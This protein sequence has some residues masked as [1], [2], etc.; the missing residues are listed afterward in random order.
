[1]S[2]GK[3]QIRSDNGKIL[4]HPSGKIMTEC[5]C[6]KDPEIELTGT[7]DFYG[8]ECD[9]D[10]DVLN[11]T[12]KN[13]GAVGSELTWARTLDMDAGLVGQLTALPASGSLAKDASEVIA[14][15]LDKN[16]LGAGSY[17]G[18]LTAD[19]QLVS[20]VTPGT[21]PITVEIVT[22][23]SFPATMYSHSV[24]GAPVYALGG[25][26]AQRKSHSFGY[27]VLWSQVCGRKPDGVW[28]ELRSPTA[29][30]GPLEMWYNPAYAFE[31]KYIYSVGNT[32][33]FF[34]E[35]ATAPWIGTTPGT[36]PRWPYVWNRGTEPATVA[37]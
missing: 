3:I 2:A 9:T 22:Y 15:S 12:I 25:S 21:L 35:S 18:T 32:R 1:M 16:G 5:C 30:N 24:I 29:P 26:G 37:L 20:G 14:V 34:S 8:V 23:A 19:E 13:V 7:L 33:Y 36:P 11:A 6:A 27:C 10:T 31:T 4:I 17:T 28:N